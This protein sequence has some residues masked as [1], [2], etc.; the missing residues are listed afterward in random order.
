M[1]NGFKISAMA[2]LLL[3]SPLTGT[4]QEEIAEREDSLAKQAQNP[5]ANLISLPFQN[6][7]SF[8]VGEFDRAQN[9]LNIQ[10]VIPFELS[11]DLNLITRWIVP[12]VSQPDV[13]QANGSTF[14]LGDINPSFFFSPDTGD[15]L[16]GFGPT[17]VLPTATSK[18][19]GAGK[20]G[21]GPSVVG[22]YTDGPWLVGFLINNIWTFGG[23]GQRPD[24]SKL[25]AQPFINYNLPDG[26]YLTTS[27]VFTADWKAD[28][29]NRWSVPLGGGVGKVTVFQGFPPINVQIQGF[30]NVVTPDAAGPAGSLRLQIQL[31]FPKG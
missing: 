28:A 21:A 22:V 31:L 17:F 7:T 3:A 9:I 29:D 1:T 2:I 5:I 8:G 14:G 25:L 11:E 30:G 13:M 26:W 12:L 24:G 20:W 18:K 27:P 10:P 4:A 16:W 6:N 15:M 23:D 19:T